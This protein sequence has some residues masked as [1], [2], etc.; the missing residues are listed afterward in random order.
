MLAIADL[1]IGVV[2]IPLYIGGHY[3]EYYH[4]VSVTENLDLVL[5]LTFFASVFNLYAVTADRYIAV[6][7]ALRYNALMT[8]RTVTLIA[9]AA[10]LCPALLIVMLLICKFVAPGFTSYV[11]FAMAIVF[12]IIP[13]ILMAFAYSKIFMEAKKQ[14]KQVASLQ[15]YDASQ[16]REKAKQRKAEH[17]VAK[18][19]ALLVFI[20]FVCWIPTCIEQILDLA[21]V[22]IPTVYTDIAIILMIAN[23]AVNPFFYGLTKQDFREKIKTIF[24]RRSGDAWDSVGPAPSPKPAKKHPND[25]TSTV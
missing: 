17:K 16:E 3:L 20:F 18:T 11:L 15:V 2:F 23:S 10:W 9:L 12:V 7:H 21:N 8:T 19:C 1:L 5:K 13:G 14:I 24:G 6:L 25:D 4:L 22:P